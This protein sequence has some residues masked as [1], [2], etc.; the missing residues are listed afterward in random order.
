MNVCPA[1][2]YMRFTGFTLAP[3]C[4]PGLQVYVAPAPFAAHVGY[5]PPILG[6]AVV[7]RLVDWLD[8]VR[9]LAAIALY[10]CKGQL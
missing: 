7:D 4:T 6:A 5:G 8:F 1:H 2:V 9:E 10:V 3:S